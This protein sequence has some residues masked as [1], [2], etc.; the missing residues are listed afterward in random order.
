MQGS[1]LD[2]LVE[3]AGRTC[4]DSCGTGRNSETY[5]Q[6]IAEVNHLSV[7]EH[8]NFTV[9]FHDDKVISPKQL[10]DTLFS[11]LNRPGVYV[12]PIYDHFFDIT[13]N[14]RSVVEW[15]KRPIYSKDAESIGQ[16]LQSEAL[17][18]APLVCKPYKFEPI[19][20]EFDVFQ[21]IATNNTNEIFC[22]IFFTNISRGLSHE[23]VR[24]RLGG[25]SQRSTRYVDESESHWCWH[26]LLKKYHDPQNT[27]K[28][29]FLFAR[30][31]H[32]FRYEACKLY[33]YYVNQLQQYLI[34]QNVDK[35]TARK[36]SRGAARGILGNALATEMLYTTSLKNWQHMIKMRA[37]EAA[38][39]EIR[40]VFNEVFE[41][42]RNSWPQ[43]F[44]EWKTTPCQ[45]GMGFAVSV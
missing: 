45:D 3:I 16:I 24:H 4:Y 43:Y 44:K 38:D 28:T 12:C 2:R 5:H 40:L 26:P 18:L 9:K 37:S 25:V 17:K 23:L 20:H 1:N 22:S 36:Q 11:L 34:G 31:L 35:F 33:D 30:D 15:D 42:L 21:K 41:I 29:V 6:H 14:L 13:V 39:A 8:A 10:T 7:L 32:N 19:D 27:N